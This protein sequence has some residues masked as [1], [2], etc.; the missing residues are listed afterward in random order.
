VRFAVVVAL[1]RL[2]TRQRAA[3]LLHDVLDRPLAEVA[4][5]LGTNANAA[6][7]LLARA[8]AALA[9]ARRHADVDVPADPAVVDRLVHAIETRSVE[10]FTALL[11][12][13]V[14]G[15]TDGGGVLRGAA[16]PVFAVRAVSRGF[17]STNRRQPLPIAAH[18]RMLNGERAVVV[19][20][21]SAGD[22]VMAAV[23]IETRGGRIVALRVARDPRRLI[24][25][26][27]AAKGDA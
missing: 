20:V 3:L 5:A 14:W 27:P 15:L 23:H 19:T 7:A 18:V 2:S 12:E 22:A 1:Q 6:K 11:A 10:A 16:K 26:G 13:D 24:H 8:R 17:A 21:P 25:L 4:E 9:H